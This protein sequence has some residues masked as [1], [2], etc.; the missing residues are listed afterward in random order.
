MVGWAWSPWA[1]YTLKYEVETWAKFQIPPRPSPLH[2]ACTPITH[3]HR[4]HYPTPLTSMIVKLCA[5]ARSVAATPTA[6][7]PEPGTSSA[8]RKFRHGLLL[9]R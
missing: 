4:Q 7:T 6:L 5:L 1:K 3:M 8:A 9:Q 2:R